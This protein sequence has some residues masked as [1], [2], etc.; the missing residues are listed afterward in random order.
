MEVTIRP[1]RPEDH[2]QIAAFTVNTFTWGDYVADAFLDWLVEPG[3]RTAVAEIGDRVVGMARAALVSP[4]E[5]WAQGARIHPDHRRRGIAT[6]LSLHLWEWARSQGALVVRLAIEDW[7]EAAQSQ[8]TAM[9][10]RPAGSWARAAGWPPVC[11]P[12][13]VSGCWTPLSQT[14]V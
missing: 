9:G 7:N 1:G 12:A 11:R 6:D 14:L 3:T 2:E 13:S 8:V 4:V 10:F 5:A